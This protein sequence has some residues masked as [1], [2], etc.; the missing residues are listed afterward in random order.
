MYSTRCGG[1][2]GASRPVE[3]WG[4]P[5]CSVVRVGEEY[6]N[7]ADETGHAARLDDFDAIAAL[8]I[9][10]IRFP[11]I[12]ETVT[13][14]T[15]G[16]YDWNEVDARIER[17]Q[18]L[19]LRPIAGLIHHGSG[20]RDTS[21]LDP[22]FP[23]KLARYAAAAAERYRWIEHW[24]PVNEPLTTARFSCLY[25]HW[26]PHRADEADFIRALVN[27]C[28]GTLLAMEAIRQVNPAAKLVQ[29]EDYGRVFSTPGLAYQADFENARRLLSLD[30]LCGRLDPSA[31][32]WK[33]LCRT[34]VDPQALRR[35]GS[36][37]ARPDIIGINHYLTSDRYLD[38]RVDLYPGVSVGGNGR[39]NYVDVEAVRVDGLGDAVGIEAR[40]GEIWSRYQIPI[41]ITEV[42]NGCT[43]EEQVRW[44]VDVWRAAE[45]LRNR[46]VDIRAV[47]IWS[48]FGAV[49]WCSLLTERRGR[50]ERG[51]FD[52]EGEQP[53]RTLLAA[54]ASEL[55]TR[56]SFSHPVL[57]TPGWWRR[58]NRFVGPHV[59]SGASP[60]LD[61]RPL[62]ITGATGTLGQAF[63]RICEARGIAHRLTSRAEFD[64]ADPVSVHQMLTKLQPW[65]V[66]NT[67]GFV[68]VADA[69][70]EQDSCFRENAEGPEQ[71]ALACAAA[72]IAL[73]TFSSDLVFDGLAGRPYVEG[74][75]VNPTSVYG[76]SK[77]E[78]ERRVL[79]AFPEALVIRTSAF[80]GPWDRHN[81]VWHALAA[82]GRGESVRANDR[83]L[84]SPTYVPDLVHASLDLLV[85]G[86]TGLWHVAN[87]GVTSW[88]Q[89]AG[90][91]AAGA[92]LKAVRLEPEGDA[93][94]T[95][96][97][98]GSS[99]GLLLRPL[100]EA[101]ASYHRELALVPAW[102]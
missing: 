19:G 3:L 67:A 63:A 47:T 48:M 2:T 40:L 68:R 96:T 94:A 5:E 83:A 12:W 55:A 9:R 87:A 37:A 18:A 22:Q 16:V 30:L 77:K 13:S 53:R 7:Q 95:N 42:H 71:L 34:D 65:A 98:L 91:A 102:G 4:G 101:L 6:R 23:E 69:E 64:I 54:A 28:Y 78:A 51:I 33:W 75:S 43:R 21:L 88:L 46:G 99:R 27:Q 97:A 100:D 82:I 17:V 29:T 56:A 39:D 25:G 1:A 85:D 49:D 59:I 44:L 93:Q 73:V 15:D 57:E 76:E 61:G 92:R 32:A 14:T 89:F 80:F 70:Q 90:M 50:I 36:G 72:G 62:L 41:A 10:T 45:R 58:T 20:P 81:F 11:I 24:T 86:E 52:F 38:E 84:V 8:G 66:V 35:L 79:A 31:P 74:D 26:Y 60:M